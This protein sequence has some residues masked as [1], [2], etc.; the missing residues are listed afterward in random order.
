M[1]RKAE[2]EADSGTIG[3]DDTWRGAGSARQTPRGTCRR[4]H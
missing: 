4:D 1:R 2:E 3:D